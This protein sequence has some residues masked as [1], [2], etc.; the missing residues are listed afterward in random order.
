M[1]AGLKEPGLLA[2]MHL[3]RVFSRVQRR[4][5]CHLGKYNLTLAQ[6]DVLARL[7]GAEGITQQTLADQLLVTKGNV[8]GLI[9][10]LSEQGLV[11]RRADPEDRRANL[12]F[13]TAAGRTLAEQ[14]VPAHQRV[15]SGLMGGLDDQEQR[16]LLALLRKLDRSLAETNGA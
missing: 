7:S 2:W 13:L 5:M 16:Q 9:D 14:V 4:E 10:R 15:L 11:E 1:K 8:C 12:L 3:M 6:F